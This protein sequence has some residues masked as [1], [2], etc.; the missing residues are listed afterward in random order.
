MRSKQ[1][2]LIRGAKL[3]SP[4]KDGAAGRRISARNLNV[5]T[6]TP[7]LMKHR[8]SLPLDP[9]WFATT[10]DTRLTA[11]PFRLATR[12]KKEPRP[13]KKPVE[14]RP[15]LAIRVQLRRK[16]VKDYTKH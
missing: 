1:S 3:F 10:S 12:S 11:F 16:K 5:E 6:A 9:S 7:D 14:R 8:W 13:S 15:I 2:G 4:I